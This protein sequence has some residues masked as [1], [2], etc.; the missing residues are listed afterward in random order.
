MIIC[1]V[2]VKWLED[3]TS[4]FLISSKS[5]FSKCLVKFP[6]YTF[7][8]LSWH[9]KVNICAS[10][11]E[12]CAVLGYFSSIYDGMVKVVSLFFFL[13]QLAICIESKRELNEDYQDCIGSMDQASPHKKVTMVSLFSLF[14]CFTIYSVFFHCVWHEVLPWLYVGR[15][16]VWGR[17]RLIHYANTGRKFWW[18]TWQVN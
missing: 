8:V 3:L 6:L 12:K 17:L 5:F 18:E 7:V 9:F 11:R 13:V 15:W 2:M 1:K 10:K 4:V 16:P 14:Q